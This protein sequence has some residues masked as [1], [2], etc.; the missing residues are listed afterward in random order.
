MTRFINTEKP[1]RLSPQPHPKYMS[2]STAF[3][4]PFYKNSFKPK[5]RKNPLFS[6]KFIKKSTQKSTQNTQVAHWKPKSKNSP[7][8]PDHCQIQWKTTHCPDLQKPKKSTKKTNP[9][10][11]VQK[12]RPNTIFSYPVFRKHRKKYRSLPRFAKKTF[13]P[14]ALEKRKKTQKNKKQLHSQ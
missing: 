10:H 12:G 14:P 3:K 2:P 13:F 5:T 8:F 11:R 9:A 4:K 1:T 7:T 6:R